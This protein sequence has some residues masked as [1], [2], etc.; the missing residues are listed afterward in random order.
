VKKMNFLM[1]L[2]PKRLSLE[3]RDEARRKDL[4]SWLD[5]YFSYG[6]VKRNWS[7]Y[8]SSEPWSF[9]L[10]STEPAAHSFWFTIYLGEHRYRISASIKSEGGGENDYLGCSCTRVRPLRGESHTRGRDLPDGKFCRE[11]FDA[12]MRAI[13]TNEFLELEIDRHV[14]RPGV[15]ENGDLLLSPEVQQQV[16]DAIDGREPVPPPLEMRRDR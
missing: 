15:A 11:T 16:L 9:R 5:E 1:N 13:T 4:I 3:E 2:I 6:G 10:G 12:I 14:T 7:D 8:L